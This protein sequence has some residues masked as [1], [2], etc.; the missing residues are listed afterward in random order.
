MRGKNCYLFFSPLSQAAFYAVAVIAVVVSITVVGSAQGFGPRLGER[1][2]EYGADQALDRLVGSPEG[3]RSKIEG[4]ILNLDVTLHPRLRS[5]PLKA[6]K[7]LWTE[8]EIG[9]SGKTP[10]DP[11]DDADDEANPPL[12]DRAFELIEQELRAKRAGFD[13]D[14]AFRQSMIFL[15]IQHAFRLATEKGS[16]ADLKGPFFAD[17]FKSVRSLRGWS[18]SDPFLVNYI[19]H[20][21][22]GA[23]GG[24]IQIQNDPKG[25]REE[26]SLDKIYWR[27]RMKAFWWAAAYS[28]QFEIGLVSEASLGN[29][30]IRPS[31]KAKHPM[32]YVDLVVTPVV[33]AGWLVGE[34]ALD[35]YIIRR[36]EHKL[37]RRIAV[38]LFRSFLNPTRS[39]ANVM[40]GK[41]PWYRDDR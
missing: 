30:G 21:M 34:D 22:M 12:P 2:L 11:L 14:A 8:S 37:S 4:G 35:R 28:T 24:R 9:S 5:L 36:F 13:W 18:D 38:I 26:I 29:I 31:R 25:A 10:D 7:I 17:Y 15:G 39:F 6:P 3:T 27:S 33:G 40:R 16:R 41:F 32:S 1:V 20:P 19:G 23:V